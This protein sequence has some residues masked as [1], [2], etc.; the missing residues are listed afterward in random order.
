MT[1]TTLNAPVVTATP[2]GIQSSLALAG[3]LLLASLFLPAGISKLTVF[4]GTVGYIQSVGLPF[5]ELAAVE[6][7]DKAV[8]FVE[9]ASD[10]DDFM[11]WCDDCERLFV[12]EGDFTERFENF[13]DARIVC[14]F[15][16]A[17]IRERHSALSGNL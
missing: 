6:A 5:P 15:C 3:R 17:N 12:E 2:T 8:G 10:P 7:K 4:A 13:C 9:D 16:Y 14:D 1:T 11:A